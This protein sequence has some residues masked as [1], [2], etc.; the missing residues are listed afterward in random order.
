[1]SA[2]DTDASQSHEELR[3]DSSGEW[4]SYAQALLATHGLGPDEI[5][6]QF[7]ETT[8]AL[9]RQF[10]RTAGVTADGVIGSAT[11]AALQASRPTG[12]LA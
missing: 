6:G 2:E 8:E 11:W 10:Q 3:L 7:T 5:D 1:M 4:V 12:E 9:V